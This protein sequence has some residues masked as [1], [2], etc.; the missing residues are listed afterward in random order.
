MVLVY[1]GNAFVKSKLQIKDSLTITSFMIL[2]NNINI[3]FLDKK[4]YVNEK[5]K[6]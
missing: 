5:K 3:L 1:P 4:S 6:D 2:K